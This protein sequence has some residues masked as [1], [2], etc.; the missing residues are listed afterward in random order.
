MSITY[1]KTSHKPPNKF[2][3]YTDDEVRTCQRLFDR[4]RSGNFDMNDKEHT[5]RHVEADDDRFEE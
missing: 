3:L 2:A 5:G 1:K 4:F